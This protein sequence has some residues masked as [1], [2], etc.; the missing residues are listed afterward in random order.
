M[1]PNPRNQRRYEPLR[2]AHLDH[3]DD[4]AI[5]FQRGEGPARFPSQKRTLD[6]VGGVL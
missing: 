4:R 1:A 2:L 6:P 5:L 3:G